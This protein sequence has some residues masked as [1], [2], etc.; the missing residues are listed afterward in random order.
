MADQAHDEILGLARQGNLQALSVYLNRHLI[1]HGAHV[2]LKQK[3]DALHVLIVV[4]RDTENQGLLTVAQNLLLRLSPAGIQTVKIYT[5]VL[6]QNQATLKQKFS[7]SA[8]AARSAADRQTLDRPTVD[9]PAG[10]AKSTYTPNPVGGYPST[11]AGHQTLHPRASYPVGQPTAYAPKY[12]ASDAAPSQATPQRYSVAEFLSQAT[13]IKDLQVLQRHPF[14]TGACPKCGHSFKNSATPPK[15]WDCPKC[16]WKDDLSSAIP[17]NKI[18]AGSAQT[19]LTESKRLGDYLVEAGLLTDSQIEVA[20]TDQLTTGLRFGEV[21]VRRGWVKEE[22]IEYLMQKVILP[23]RAGLDQ[24]LSSILA[25][26]RNLLRTIL[27]EP[28]ESPLPPADSLSTR[29]DGA[30]AASEARDSAPAL[31]S[32]AKLPNERETLILPD[33]DMSEYLKDA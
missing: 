16:G 31:P 28:S 5:Q 13:D 29:F 22:T 15:Y 3:D 19:S 11:R 21:L 32:P 17:R 33:L 10:G 8:A 4:M 9:R 18:H 6:G 12:P 24:N 27:Q 2:K 7:I 1:P 23:E 25:S 14:V 20:L 30:V 26:S